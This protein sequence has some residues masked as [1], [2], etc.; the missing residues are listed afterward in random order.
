MHRSY[1]HVSPYDD[2]NHATHS[3]LLPRQFTG[4]GLYVWAGIIKMWFQRSRQ[5]RA[6]AELDDRMLCDIGVT[7]SQAQR[8]AAKPIWM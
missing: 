7:R 5:R 8:E 3:A 1:R 4:G 2:T 6:L